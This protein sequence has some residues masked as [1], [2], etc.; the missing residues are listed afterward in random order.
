MTN[1]I[2]IKINADEITRHLT[3]ID[4]DKVVEVIKENNYQILNDWFDN[5][6]VDI[7]NEM[8]SYLDD[9]ADGYI[10]SWIEDNLDIADKV[11][12]ALRYEISISDYLDIDEEIDLESRIQNL[13]DQYRP[14]NGC[15]TGDA[16]TGVIATGLKYVIHHNEEEVQQTIGW[17]VRN[18]VKETIHNEI[19]TV[20][21]P[22]I[23]SNVHAIIAEMFAPTIKM[24]TP[25]TSNVASDVAYMS[26]K[27]QNIAS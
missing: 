21:R 4:K 7:S 19:E 26:A 2:N 9:H 24:L 3:N 11:E 8:S 18:I 10:E 25:D 27:T 23:K 22:L 6:E 12:H 13:A 16:I 15:S 1:E 20:L 14:G 17:V 5:T